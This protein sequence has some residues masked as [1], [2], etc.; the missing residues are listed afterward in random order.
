MKKNES[1]LDRIVRV[2]IGV[3]L[4][5][6]HASGATTGW[7]AYLFLLLGGVLTITGAVGFSPLY[8]LIKHLAKK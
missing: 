3:T 1:G 6:L 4:I 2:A 5:T 7:L 8:A